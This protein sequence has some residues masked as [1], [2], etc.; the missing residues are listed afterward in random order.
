[1]N[2]TE[3]D[4]IRQQFDQQCTE[5]HLQLQQDGELKPATIMSFRSGWL[6]RKGKLQQMFA[7]L[8]DVE[9]DQRAKLG[10]DL[11][12]LK[13]TLHTA[14]EDLDQQI[15]HMQMEKS[16]QADPVDVTLPVLRL[17]KSLHPVTVM[18]QRVCE[19][20]C[21]FGYQVFDGPEIETDHY[22]FQAL[23][24]PLHHPAR[25]MQ[26]SFYIAVADGSSGDCPTD[27]FFNWVMRTQTS[28][29]QI[30]VMEK[31]DPPLRIIAPGRVF[32][33]DSDSTH[34]PLFHQ[35]EGLVVDEGISLA[36]LKGTIEAFLK[37]LFGS[38]VEMRLRPSYFPFVEPGL[39]IDIRRPVGQASSEESGWLEVG[40][41]GMVH[42]NVIETVG[43]DSED[44]TGFAFGFG[45]D[46]LAMIAYGIDD[47]RQLFSGDVAWLSQFSDL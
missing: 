4:Q 17:Q 26:D 15:S 13:N 40:G 6:G 3:I 18:T 24:I 38:Q 27:S 29:V 16:L 11:N 45:V 5:L 1:M 7:Q 30:H 25:A 22:N 19:I 44:L 37:E 21:R 2:I 8:R 46:R 23:N 35:C 47:L 12:E 10:R 41:C 28:N 31:Y 9:A 43:Y 39:E 14:F 36:D 33:I 42:P 34:T 20:F 32:R